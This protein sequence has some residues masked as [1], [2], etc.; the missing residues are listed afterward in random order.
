MFLFTFIRL[1]LGWEVIIIV[2]IWEVV[3]IDLS[4]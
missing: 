2:I 3:S 4:R 1:L